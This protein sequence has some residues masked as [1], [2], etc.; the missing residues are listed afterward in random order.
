[1][2]V[3]SHYRESSGD[4]CSEQDRE[5]EKTQEKWLSD[6]PSHFSPVVSA[7]STQFYR[8]QTHTSIVLRSL[9]IKFSNPV[10]VYC[11]YVYNIVVVYNTFF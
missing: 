3:M 7:P 9:S 11:D 4:S 1:M 8:G 5:G 6:A 2:R 10:Q